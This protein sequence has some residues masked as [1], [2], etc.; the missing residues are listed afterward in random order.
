MNN[1]TT[2]IKEITTTS[3]DNTA[4]LILTDIDMSDDTCTQA[5]CHAIYK[6]ANAARAWENGP[7]WFCT[8]ECAVEYLDNAALDAY[9]FAEGAEWFN[10]LDTDALVILLGLIRTEE[11]GRSYDDEVIDALEARN[12][13]FKTLR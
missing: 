13:D 8:T 7:A 9:G 5:Q 12:F 6:S 10:A 3:I 4:I 1:T 2:N 11:F